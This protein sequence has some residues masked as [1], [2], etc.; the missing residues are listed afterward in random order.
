MIVTSSGVPGNVADNA[1]ASL[2]K[3]IDQLRAEGR[4]DAGKKTHETLKWTDKA[5]A[6]AQ[7]FENV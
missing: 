7:E 5:Y 6:A 2:D 3:E 4:L 1:R